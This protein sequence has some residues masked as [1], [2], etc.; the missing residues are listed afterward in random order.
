MAVL[1]FVATLVLIKALFS[2]FNG[3]EWGSVTDWLSAAGSV[4]TLI[5]AII[6]LM[7]VPDWMAQ[8][9]YDIAYSI[10]ENAVYK[11]LAELRLKSLH[12]K[13]LT[14]KLARKIVDSV[15]TDGEDIN[16][17][18]QIEQLNQA[19]EIQIDE[20]DRLAFGIRNQF[21][22]ALRTNYELSNYAHEIENFIQ[23]SSKRYNVITHQIYVV[24]SEFETFYFTDQKKKSNFEK[25][26]FI[27]RNNAIKNNKYLSDKI[28][29]I[30]NE[31]R[32]IK[33]F[34]TPKRK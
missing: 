24:L 2:G 23:E 27:I 19:V 3:F 29:Q 8:K 31:N 12:V 28:N 10:I 18:K 9:H 32:P 14:L 7:K 17:N 21:S 6:A 22:S 26:I 5:I 25:E 34:I 4:G 30:Y 33:E 15:R 1:S 11:D 13:N 16:I 20:F